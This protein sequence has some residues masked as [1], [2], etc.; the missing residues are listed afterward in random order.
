M[1]IKLLACHGGNS[2][3]LLPIMIPLVAGLGLS[4]GLGLAIRLGL[5][6]GLG[7]AIVGTRST[8]CRS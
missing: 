6:L 8:S 1:A 5:G 2:L 7:C 4:I 3:D